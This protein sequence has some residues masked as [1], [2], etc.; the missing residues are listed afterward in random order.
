MRALVLSGGGVKGAYQAG[1]VKHLAESGIVFDLIC[2][3]SVGAINAAF[4]A[5]YNKEN[6]L[7]GTKDLINF[8]EN[9]EQK[10]VY[11]RWFPFGMLHALWKQSLYNSTPLHKLINNHIDENK[12]FSSKVKLRVGTVSVKNDEYKIYDQNSALIKQAVMASASFPPYFSPVQIIDDY[13]YD[14][15]LREYTPIKSAIDEGAT[16][17]YIISTEIPSL[18][19]I[20][21]PKTLKTWDLIKRFISAL[22]AEVELNDFNSIEKTNKK[23]IDGLG[24][25]KRY[26]KCH[27]IQPKKFLTDKPLNFKKDLIV[28]LIKTGY[29]D[30]IEQLK[31]E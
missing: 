19:V 31:N 15:G 24:G 6:L 26:I 20:S 23:V 21:N 12:I 3:S 11:K 2:G 13:E 29:N 5:Q 28:N 17:I 4:L 27:L 1:V 16:E 14:A 18:P 10:S 30:S 9:M 7:Q 25:D 8:W 22:A